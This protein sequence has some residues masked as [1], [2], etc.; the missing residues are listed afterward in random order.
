[1]SKDIYEISRDD[2]IKFLNSYRRAKIDEYNYL[3]EADDIASARLFRGN[4]MTGMPSSHGANHD[5][6][7]VIER[8]ID[9]QWNKYMEL[10]LQS[11]EKSCEVKNAIN[12]LE[13]PEERKVLIHKY[14]LLK[15]N[16]KPK[17]WEEISQEIG[18]CR[19]AVIK[20]HNSA[21]EKITI[22]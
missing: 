12:L 21:L 14:I 6:S 10:R 5:I 15:H 13:D 8:L 16:F 4:A 9:E 18:Y 11:I 2:K 17:T 20:Y 19:T 3:A 7:D 22:I 1:M